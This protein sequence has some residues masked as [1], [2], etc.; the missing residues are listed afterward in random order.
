MKILNH[1]RMVEADISGR[2]TILSFYFLS[3]QELICKPF[4]AHDAPPGT[5]IRWRCVGWHCNLGP[6]SGEQ[7]PTLTHLPTH[8]SFVSTFLIFAHLAHLLA[9]PNSPAL[10]L[11]TPLVQE[12]T[13]RWAAHNLSLS[14]WFCV[15]SL[16]GGGKPYEPFK[17][18]GK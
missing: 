6:I 3:M 11:V 1:H 16:G 4:S 13:S 5:F 14:V 9:S 2:S 15:S 17:K 18:R 10:S 8:R 7:L 12:L